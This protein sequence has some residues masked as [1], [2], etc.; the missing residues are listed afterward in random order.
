MNVCYLSPCARRL[1]LHKTD[2][3]K[4]TALCELYLEYQILAHAERPF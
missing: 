3:A 4:F 1:K 2:F